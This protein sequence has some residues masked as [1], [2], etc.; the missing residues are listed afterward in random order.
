MKWFELLKR[1]IQ[2]PGRDAPRALPAGRA[3]S[4][5]RCART[6]STSSSARSSPRWRRSPGKKLDMDELAAAPVAAREQAE[7][8]LVAVWEIARHRPSPI[9]GY[10]GGVYYVGPIFSSFRGTEDAVDLLPR[11]ARGGGGAHRAQARADDARR[12]RVKEKYRLVVEGPP[13]WTSFHDFWRMFSRE[14]AVVVVEHLHA[15]RRPL[16]HGLP[17]R[18]EPPARDAS[19]TTASVATRTSACPTRVEAARA[20]TSAS[21][22]PTGSSSTA[23][24]AATRSASGSC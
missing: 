6:S 9:D 13:N 12:R 23:S 24:R 4:P 7:D 8:D 19:P 20:S 16:R 11:A 5:R 14:G 18:P 3:S 10:F 17:P 2:V 22:R 21:T 15:R 1:G